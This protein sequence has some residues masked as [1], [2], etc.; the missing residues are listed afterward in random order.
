M[1]GLKRMRLNELLG[2]PNK[3]PNKWEEL[4][5]V[6]FIQVVFLIMQYKIGEMSI[7]ELQLRLYLE[8][9]GINNR[10]ILKK[11]Y[12]WMQENIFKHLGKM[13][14]IFMHIYKDERFELLSES[15]K[16][17]LEKVMPE[18]INDPEAVIAR[19]FEKVTDIDLCFAKQLIPNIYIGLKSYAGYNFH[20]KS[21]VLN[22]SMTAEQYIDAVNTLSE[23]SQTKNVDSLNLLCSILYCTPYSSSSAIVQVGKFAKLDDLAKGAII[24]NFEAIITWLTTKTKYKVLFSPAGKK[25]EKNILGMGTI[26]YSLV[27]KGYGK[28]DEIGNINLIAFFDLMLKNL[29]DAAQEMKSSKMKDTE[30]ADALNIT[31]DTLNLLI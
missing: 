19:T 8:L 23:Y 27:E 7:K 12:E 24:L 2:K 25:S 28:L 4:T 15:M 5:P 31:L 30:I 3:F 20:I 29:Q 9:A 22:T 26:L 1:N 10:K 16:K 13:S 6:Q 11:S 17:K 14:F 21:G 18:E